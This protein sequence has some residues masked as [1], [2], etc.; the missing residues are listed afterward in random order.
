MLHCSSR[1]SRL[2]DIRDSHRR[3]C[4]KM[5][6]NSKTRRVLEAAFSREFADEYM[7]KVMFDY[8]DEPVPV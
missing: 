8:E 5:L 7:T 1:A 3:Y 4:D 6:E 2:A